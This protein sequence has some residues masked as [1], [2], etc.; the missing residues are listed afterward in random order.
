MTA[1][2]PDPDIPD[3]QP[4]RHPSEAPPPMT[5]PQPD[6]D[7]SREIPP[8]PTAPE[9]DPPEAYNSEQDGE[10]DDIA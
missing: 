8:G 5:E 9:M 2:S 1:T 4:G 10:R 7:P 6:S 3:I